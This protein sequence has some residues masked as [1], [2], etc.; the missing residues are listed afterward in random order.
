MR[1]AILSS[2]LICIAAAVAIH[3]K[4]HYQPVFEQT[5]SPFFQ[6]LGKP[7]QTVD[8]TVTHLFPISQV[9]EKMLGRR[10]KTN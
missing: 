3:I 5:F 9:D 6:L 4:E 2:L 8:R 7:L 10:S 1:I